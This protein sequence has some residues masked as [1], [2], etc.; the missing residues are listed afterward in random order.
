MSQSK[1]VDKESHCSGH[2]RRTT[3]LPTGGSILEVLDELIEVG[4]TMGYKMDGC[5][6]AQK[7]KKDWVKEICNKHKDSRMFRKHNSTVSDYFVSIQ[8]DWIPNAKKYLIISVYAPQ[9]ISEK[10]MLWSYLNHVIDSWS[11]ETFIMGDFN[12]VR[13]KE[14]RFGTIFNDH[15]AIAFNSFISSGGLV[16]VPLGGCAFTWCH[17]SG[18]K[19][20][21]L[22]RFLISE[23]L[24]G[25][26]P[27]ISAITL[28]RYLSDHRPILLREACYDYGPIPFRMFHYWFEWEDD[29]KV[30]QELLNK[31]VHVMN[32]LHDL[33]KLEASEVA[34]KVKINWSIEGDENSR[35]F[36]GMLNKKRNQQA[37]RG[38][39]KEGTWLE[40][41][42][43]VKNE[44][45]SQFKEM[46]D[47]P[48]SSRLMLDMAFPNRVS[49]EQLIELERNVSKEEIKRA[50]WDC[51]SD[52][53][54]GP[55]GFTF[56]FYRRYWDTI[57][58]DVVDVVSYFFSVVDFEKAYDS[59]RW[60]YLDDVLNKFGFGSKWRAWIHNCLV[61]SKGSILVNG[62][63]TGGYAVLK[64]FNM[65]LE[66]RPRA[67]STDGIRIEGL[68]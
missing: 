2:F 47:S 21:K 48:S 1:D 35:Y 23:G 4:Q 16:E 52:K 53:S 26:C 55:D 44:F 36:H 5:G 30:D 9:E 65:S 37:I 59:V 33:E 17:K 57:E 51:G 64:G 61:S 54:P 34:Q 63:P 29:K 25:S 46:F 13:S 56:G 12:E 66:C 10:I 15:N 7:A 62:S 38:I 42:I 19:M 22:D 58:K 24:M 60:D 40:D 49:T 11:G 32:S 14:E 3:C 31:R 20:S 28:D 41:P 27:N 68:S 8:G 39:L 43:S 45:L 67:L 6:L 18:S 50:V